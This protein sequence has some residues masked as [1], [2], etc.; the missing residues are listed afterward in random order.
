MSRSSAQRPTLL[1]ALRRLWRDPRRLQLGTDP[2]RA[3]VLEL[4]D[5]LLA[6]LL[7]LLDGTRTEGGVVREAAALGVAADEA[8]AVLHALRGAGLVLDS[9]ALMPDDLG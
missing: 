9:T 4:A 8:F 2:G 1:P 7:D 3:V 6:R 5:P